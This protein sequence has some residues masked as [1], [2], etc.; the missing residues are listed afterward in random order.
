MTAEGRE[1]EPD[2]YVRCDAQMRGERCFFPSLDSRAWHVH[3]EQH[4]TLTYG[5]GHSEVEK[6][7]ESRRDY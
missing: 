5:W 6:A 4:E 3:G 2:W 1:Q 7:K